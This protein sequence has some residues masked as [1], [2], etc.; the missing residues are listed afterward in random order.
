MG[1]KT[2]KGILIRAA[3]TAAKV[4]GKPFAGGFGLGTFV[5]FTPDWSGPMLEFIGLAPGYA[6]S[7]MVGLSAFGLLSVGYATWKLTPRLQMELVAPLPTSIITAHVR[8]RLKTV[9][10]SERK[11]VVRAR[12]YKLN[13][14]LWN[15]VDDSY[16]LYSQRRLANVKAKKSAPIGPIRIDGEGKVIEVCEFDWLQNELRLY[17]EGGVEKLGA[18]WRFRIEVTASGDG[19]KMSK[20]IYVFSDAENRLIYASDDFVTA[21]KERA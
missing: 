11:V 4:F 21:E 2:T 10:Q 5:L 19:Q 13:N 3:V 16:V 15:S 1:L 18:D 6:S 20:N 7:F 14:K 12:V 8:V 9:D 17:H